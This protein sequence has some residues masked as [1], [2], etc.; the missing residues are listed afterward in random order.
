MSYLSLLWLPQGWQLAH[1]EVQF[2]NVTVLAPLSF[3]EASGHL[4]RLPFRPSSFHGLPP[5]L[6]GSHKR[7]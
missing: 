4:T 6:Q 3:R 7:D 5:R 1:P 2:G